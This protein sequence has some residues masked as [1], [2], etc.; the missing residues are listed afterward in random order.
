ME[1]TNVVFAVAVACLVAVT[2]T[3]VYFIR[4]L[5]SKPCENSQPEKNGVANKDP[6]GESKTIP[7]PKKK[8]VFEHKKIS[9]SNFSHPWLSKSL[10]AH[11]GNVLDADMSSSGKYFATA[12][13][14]RS[15][16]LWATSDF[17]TKNNTHNKGRV[18]FDH[19]LRV[20]WSPDSK[21]LV[22]Y[23][24][25]AN[26]V[27]VYKLT[28]SA[29]GKFSGFE[30]VVTF[31]VLHESGEIAG[32]GIDI[33]GR[34]IMTCSTDNE[35]VIWTLKGEVL[36][37]MNTNMGSTHAAVLSPCGRFV[38]VCGFTPDV[39]VM[40]VVFSKTG[41]FEKVNRSFDLKGHTSGVFHVSTNTDS[42]K[43]ATVSKD[44]S[45]KMFDTKIDYGKGQEPSLLFSI[46]FDTRGEK[47]LIALSPDGR[48]VAIA[49]STDVFFYSG[50]TGKFVKK[51]EHVHEE[52]ITFLVFDPSNKF[53][54]SGGDKQVRVFHNVVGYLATIE[55]LEQKKR[56]ASHTAMRDRIADQIAEAQK[57]LASLGEC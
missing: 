37:R 27:E 16:I 6:I 22:T 54:L 14:D 39:K 2:S 35:L 17:S 7:Q 3:L 48:S 19:A 55:D 1:D 33:N 9:K 40:E 53:L 5:S 32:M 34:Y 46:A 36:H 50:V 38:T 44:N 49:S 42:T 21:A 23:K 13:E 29:E 47:A 8:N 24:A 20:C 45:W 30:V 41:S 56:T 52:P 4:Y 57:F 28:K 43:M 18:E 31:P 25:A 51:I 12:S 15:I 10:K 11:T 26:C